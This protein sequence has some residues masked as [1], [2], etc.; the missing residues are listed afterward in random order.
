MISTELR[1]L[2]DALARTRL[3]L[4]QHGDRFTAPRLHDLEGRLSKGDTSAI[5]SAVS[6]ATGGSGSLCDRILSVENGDVIAPHDI[7]SVN[8]RLTALVNEVEQ[9][10]R[11]AASAHHIRL[12]R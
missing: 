9:R 11:A 10:G 1:S 6:E 12:M 4:Q 5:V 3:L 2:V 8:A 7:A